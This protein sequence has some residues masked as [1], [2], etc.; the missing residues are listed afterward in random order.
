MAE[1]HDAGNLTAEAT[2]EYGRQRELLLARM[3]KIEGQARGIRSMIEDDRYC[4]DIVQQLTALTSAAQE[5][6]LLI[7]QS[8]IEGCVASAIREQRGEPAIHELMSVIRKALK[9][10]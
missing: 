10:G 6:S 4:L 8:H 1:C 5:V 3:R 2:Y 7:M 9:R